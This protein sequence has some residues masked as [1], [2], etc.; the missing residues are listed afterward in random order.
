MDNQ[1]KQ[2]DLPNNLSAF[3][4]DSTGKRVID[5][6]IKEMG[7]AYATCEQG[8]IDDVITFLENNRPPKIL[9]IDLSNSELPMTDIERIQSICPPDVNILCVGTKNDVGL[10]RA[11][12]RAGIKDYIVK[13]LTIDFVTRTLSS[14]IAGNDQFDDSESRLGKIVTCIG[15]TGGIGTTTIATNCSWLL[16]NKFFKRTVVLDTDYQFGNTNLLLDLKSDVSYLDVLE[17][18]DKIDDYFVE[19]SLKRHGPKLFY[20]GGLIDLSRT[21]D[22]DPEAFAQFIQRVRKQFNY[23]VVDMKLEITPLNKVLIAQTNTFVIIAD[24]STAAAYNASRFIEY[25]K[26]ESRGKNVSIVLNKIG[27]YTRGAMSKDAFEKIVSMPVKHMLPFDAY[28]A[29]GAANVGQPIASIDCSLNSYLDDIVQD[30]LGYDLDSSKIQEV[31]ETSLLSKESLK[32]ALKKVGLDNLL[33]DKE[34]K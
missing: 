8:E 34:K 16:A 33:Q 15:V 26:Q 25:L 6:A 2:D 3:V 24:L 19:T 23:V 10:F 12:L 17:S 5:E 21:L 27:E 29:Y 30:I 7:L 9:L 11:L 20:L 1:K 18:P 4:C 14:I 13:P 31:Y 32:K 28:T 22:T